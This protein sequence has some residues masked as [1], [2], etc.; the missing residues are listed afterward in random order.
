MTTGNTFARNAQDTLWELPLL[1]PA[2]RIDHLP[3]T[4]A[5]SNVGSRIR[6]RYVLFGVEVFL[7]Q[8][9]EPT[10]SLPPSEVRN[11]G[12]TLREILRQLSNYEMRVVSAHLV[13]ILPKGV[14]D[15][16]TDLI[17]L[18]VADFSV[19]NMLAASILAH[20]G[21]FIPE[22]QARLAPKRQATTDGVESYIGVFPVGGPRITLQLQNVTIREILDRVSEET[23]R[24]PPGQRPLGWVYT[25]N[26]DDT[27]DVPKHAWQ[28][29]PGD[30]HEQQVSGEP[31]R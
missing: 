29:L 8:G 11:L 3:L 13:E 16:P 22:L 27:T 31:S 15:D 4:S 20:P 2:E 17:N 26:S 25:V 12:S 5:L 1:P 23:E 7:Q 14:R 9:K 24:P 21:R 10:V 6:G 30:W 18:R 28:T 19:T